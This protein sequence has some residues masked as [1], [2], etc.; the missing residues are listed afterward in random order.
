MFDQSIWKTFVK[1][2]VALFQQYSKD[3]PRNKISY[4]TFFAWKPFYIH[5][6]STKNMVMCCCKI[7]LHTCWSIRVFIR[8]MKKQ[9]ILLP[10]TDYF[11]FFSFLY[12]DCPRDG[13]TH[14]SW[15]C[16]PDKKSLCANITAKWVELK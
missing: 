16:T 4:G 6:A 13:S 5:H 3:D 14:I 15:K 9:E 1:T 10:F 7:H 11:T 12:I 2:Y 8:C